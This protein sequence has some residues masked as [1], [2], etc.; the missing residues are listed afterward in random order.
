MGGRWGLVL[1]LLAGCGPVIAPE[2]PPAVDAGTCEPDGG[3]E[4]GCAYRNC[5]ATSPD[6]SN[7]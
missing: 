4:A 1:V 6:P 2:V 7:C 5:L 3:G